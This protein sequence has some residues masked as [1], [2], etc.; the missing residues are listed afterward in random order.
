IAPL[1]AVPALL[2]EFGIDPEPLLRAHGIKDTETFKDPEATMPFAIGGRLLKTCAERTLC[3][4]FGLLVGQR[5]D[6]S[7]LEL[8]RSPLR[9][10]PDVITALNELVT[11]LDLH[12]RG[13]TCFL[14]ISGNDALSATR[15]MCMVLKEPTKSATS[16]WRSA[17]TSCGRYADRPGCLARSACGT[18]IR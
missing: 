6:T 9:N 16:P 13:A 10:A 5:P 2:R 1:G 11:N 17:G 18:N 7:V 12:D 3:P 14:D 4:Y 8:G 15:F